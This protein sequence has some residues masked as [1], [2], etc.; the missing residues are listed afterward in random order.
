MDPG[1]ISKIFSSAGTSQVVPGPSSGTI[2]NSNAGSL[3][4]LPKD[5]Y[6]TM[7]LNFFM[8]VLSLVG[9]WLGYYL[10][11]KRFDGITVGE[12][13]T[14][15]F[16]SRTGPILYALGLGALLIANVINS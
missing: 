2:G 16:C 6:S 15:V 4:I 14:W 10:W 5:F 7:G 9:L 8:T 11:K 12:L 1:T 3:D 13:K